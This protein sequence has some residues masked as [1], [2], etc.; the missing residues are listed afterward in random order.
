MTCEGLVFS[1]LVGF[2]GEIGDAVLV[3]TWRLNMIYKSGRSVYLSEKTFI[4]WSLRLRSILVL[5]VVCEGNI[6]RRSEKRE[7]VANGFLLL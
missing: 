2:E 7:C 1:D 5:R 3:A 4:F 6:E